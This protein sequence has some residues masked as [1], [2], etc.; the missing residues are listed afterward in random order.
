MLGRPDES[1]HRAEST[2]SPGRPPHTLKVETPGRLQPVYPKVE[3]PG[4]LQ[5]VL[6]LWDS[7]PLLSQWGRTADSQACP[8]TSSCCLRRTESAR[9]TNLPVLEICSLQGL[10]SLVFWSPRAAGLPRHS[11][12]SGQ[13]LSSL[14]PPSRLPGTSVT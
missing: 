14:H 8:H 5:P 2:H 7:C 11:G 4:R 9:Q 12:I 1:E 6:H 13:T 10:S 3:R